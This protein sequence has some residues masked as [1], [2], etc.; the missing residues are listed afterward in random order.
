VVVTFTTL[1]STGRTICQVKIP[2]PSG[3]T[4]LFTSIR[5]IAFKLLNTR[6]IQ[7]TGGNITNLSGTITLEHNGY[8]SPGFGMVVL[9]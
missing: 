8:A 1:E 5:P 7:Q 4:N 6:T 2:E 9:F 3:S